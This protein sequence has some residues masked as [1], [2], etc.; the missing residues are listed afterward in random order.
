MRHRTIDSFGAQ[1]TLVLVVCALSL[2]IR[3]GVKMRTRATTVQ[4]PSLHQGIKSPLANRSV[5]FGASKKRRSSRKLRIRIRT[6]PRGRCFTRNRELE[7]RSCRPVLF[8]P[9]SAMEGFLNC[10]SVHLKS[11]SGPLPG[12]GSSYI[13]ATALFCRTRTTTRRFSACPSAVLSSPTWW[14]SPIAPG[15]SIL[16]RGMWPC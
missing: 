13:P 16:V 14:L 2:L 11:V 4:P 12:Q 7:R 5:D 15:A 1:I 10:S 9:R 8:G 6:L 3:G